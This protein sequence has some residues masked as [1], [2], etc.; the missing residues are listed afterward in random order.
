MRILEYKEFID[1]ESKIGHSRTNTLKEESF[2]EILRKNCKNYSI[3]NDQ[4]WRGK[5]WSGEFGIFEKSERMGTIGTYSYKDFFDFR[6]KNPD[7]PVD[8]HSSLIGSTKREGSDVLTGAQSM[9]IVIPFDDSEIIFAG[10][11][12][13]GLWSKVKQTFSDELFILTNYTNDFKVPVIDL[14]RIMSKTN[15]N[16]MVDTNEFGF[17]YFSNGPCLLLHESKLDWLRKEMGE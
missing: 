13:L 17:E 14:K 4:L 10:S 1:S 15:L 6:T 2:L 8:R 5:T 11:P 12:D 16:G 7:Y 9:Y 3:N